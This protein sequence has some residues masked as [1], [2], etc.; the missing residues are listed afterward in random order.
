MARLIYLTNVSL[1]GFIE[2]ESG[3]FDWT[4]PDEE[5]FAFLTE[6]IRP[7]DTHLYGRR[8]YET[9]S[10]WETD[11][12]FAAQSEPMAE[13]ANLWQSASKI[14]YSTTLNNVW[15]ANTRLEPSFDAESVRNIKSSATSDLIIGGANL[16]AHAFKSGLVDEC[17][18]VIR[19]VLVGGGKPA[20]PGGIHA[21]LELL[22]AR[23][24]GN[25]AAYLRYRIPT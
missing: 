10:V 2:D 13:F 22:E 6:L 11:P 18:L 21:D 14:V 8:L 5:L 25:G 16:A 17:R 20:L 15:T 3:S 23:S 24:V 9:M 4:A 1:D 7:V 12:A 19:P